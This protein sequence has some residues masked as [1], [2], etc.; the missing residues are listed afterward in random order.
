MLHLDVFVDGVGF[1]LPPEAIRVLLASMVG[2]V[3]S[4]SNIDMTTT[5]T[6]DLVR[7]ALSPT[8]A[9]TGNTQ[10]THHS[11]EVGNGSDF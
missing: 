8:S 1:I 2:V 6:G 11:E 5:T 3:G 10:N 9:I 7:H 4:L